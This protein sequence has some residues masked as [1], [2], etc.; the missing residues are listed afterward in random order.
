MPIASS[1]AAREMARRRHS[2]DALRR[3]IDRLEGG[4]DEQ[5][6]LDAQIDALVGSAPRLS[7]AQIDRLRSL[8]APLVKAAR[9]EAGQ[10]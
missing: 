2:P 1:D 9:Q 8:F 3:Q 5:A 6:R 10:T 4:E 7:E